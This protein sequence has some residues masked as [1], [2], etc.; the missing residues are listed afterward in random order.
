M[1]YVYQIK[2]L[3]SQIANMKTAGEDRRHLEVPTQEELEDIRR[4]YS[5]KK[6]R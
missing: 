4:K 1:F 5:V 3:Q 2:V 6:N